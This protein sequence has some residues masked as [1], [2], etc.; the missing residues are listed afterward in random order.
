MAKKTIKSST[1]KGRLERV[2]QELVFQELDKNGNI[3]N[4]ISV[5]DFVDD[6]IGEYGVTMSIGY[7]REF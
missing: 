7:D 4:E 5:M 3:I 2:G 1:A 6:Y